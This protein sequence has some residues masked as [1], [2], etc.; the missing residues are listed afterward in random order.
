[1]FFAA[2]YFQRHI[3]RV[4]GF[5]L[6]FITVLSAIGS[7]SASISSAAFLAKWLQLPTGS[8]ALYVELMAITRYAQVVVSV[9]GMAFLTILA[10]LAYFRQLSFRIKPLLAAIGVVLLIV[11]FAPT[12]TTEL[13]KLIFKSPINLMNFFVDPQLTKGVR[14]TIASNNVVAVNSN[15]STLARI[16]K[17]HVLR[18]GYNANMM[19]FVY[20][21]NKHQ[22]VGYD[23]AYMYALAKILN[24]RI[25]F[26]P[27]QWTTSVE[28]IMKNKFDIAIGSIYVTNSRL[29]TAAFTKPYFRDK[30]SLLVRKGEYSLFKNISSVRDN[31]QVKIAVFNDPAMLLLARKY[32]SGSQIVVVDNYRAVLSDTNIDAFLLGQ[33]H[34][35]AYASVYHQRFDSISPE[36]GVN[37]K[38]FLI[39]FMLN[40]H[41]RMFLSFLNYWLTLKKNDGF[42]ARV[43]SYWLQGKPRTKNGKRW[44]VL[45]NVLGD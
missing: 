4:E 24:A 15:V 16:E 9:M 33:E 43:A 5:Y 2:F 17:T 36:W 18:V 41:D 11:A 19:P 12:T 28:D 26:I 38:P 7:P 42:Q 20:F 21:N 23:V 35:Q 34:S 30:I 22:L 25:V 27:F 31:K 45:Q 10:T 13:Q 1:M 8:T 3:G 40:K 39:A 14:V 32:F 37:P 44:S 29:E 6:P